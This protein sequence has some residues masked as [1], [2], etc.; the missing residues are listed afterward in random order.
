[1]RPLAVVACLLAVVLAGIVGWV[2]GGGGAARR[3]ETAPPE[4]A[5]ASEARG[6]G[7]G[8]PAGP[9]LAAAPAERVAASPSAGLRA[10]DVL[11]TPALRRRAEAELRRGWGSVRP[12]E[13]PQDDLGEGATKYEAIVLESP[14][15][16]GRQLGE[17]RTKAEAALEDA[18]TGGLFALL[19]A[20]AAGGVGPLVEVVRDAGRF[21][22]F[23]ARDA[24]EGARS[25]LDDR[26]HPDALVGDGTTLTW[27][28]GVFRVVN[29][30]WEKSPYPRDVTL[31]GA[32]IDAT[33][34]VI[35]DGSG[36]DALV[37]NGKSLRNFAIRDCTVHTNGNYLLYMHTLPV[38]VRFERV[39]F[40]GFDAGAGG[41]CLISAGALALTARSCRFEGGYG[42]V[43]SSGT[44]IDVRSDAVLCRF[45]GC[46]FSLLSLRIWDWHP[47]ATAVFL[48]CT[49][50]RMLDD[51]MT[52]A[53]LKPGVVFDGCSCSR[54]EGTWDEV[55]KLDLNALFPN[56]LQRIE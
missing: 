12:D 50:D 37:T 36:N 23:F 45:E 48:G 1:M 19:D 41:S 39:R 28:A 15:S 32:G 8:E 10:D 55:P 7:D 17:R 42:L 47:G 4:A 49:L 33:M 34:L 11:I 46:T 3:I 27:P 40:V 14:Y 30:M 13:M 26:E 21:E 51:A 52:H 5:V 25:A 31:A 6:Q 54:F 35:G 18:R 16:I 29:L 24:E 38:S 56:W 43:P 20:L 22:P 44:L 53:Q 9:E 2:L